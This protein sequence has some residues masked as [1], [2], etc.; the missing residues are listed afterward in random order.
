MSTFFKRFILLFCG[1]LFSGFLVNAQV[2]M[3]AS[4]RVDLAT[5]HHQL[6]VEKGVVHPDLLARYPI[7]Q[8]NGSY[9]L[10]FLG[11]ISE[12]FNRTDLIK[13][14]F[15]V[16]S[17]IA[18]LVSIKVPLNKTSQ[19]VNIKGLAYLEIA[20]KIHNSLDK[21]IVDMRADSVHQGIGLPQGYSGKDVYIGVTDWGFDYTNPVFYDTAMQQ[22][23]IVAAWDQ[24]KTSGPH[25]QGFAYGTEYT[26]QGELLAAGSDTAN[27]Y[28]YATH[29]THVSCIAGGGGAGTPHKG[30]AYDA[31]FL[32]VT[33]LVDEAA[34]LDAWEWMYQKAQADGKRLV[35]NMSWGLYHFGTLDG[36]SILSQ[37]IT[38]YTDLGVVFANSGGNNG[39]VNFHIKKTFNQDQFKSRIEFYSYSANANMWGQSVHAWGEAGNSFEN[40]LLITNNAGNTLIESPFY[41]TAT[42]TNYI[43][44]FLVTGI[45]TIWFNITAD[46]AHPLNGR[47]QMRLRV[48]NTNTALRVLLKSKA[49][50]GTVHYWNVTELSNDVGNWGMPFSFSYGGSISGDN[51]N[52]ISEPS[53]SE[54]V[55][56][57]AAYS[58]QYLNGSGNPV[59][60][61]IASF[62]SVG[63]RYD[64]QMKPDIAA[65]G[66]AIISAMSSFTDATFSSVDNVSFNNKTYHFAKMSGTSMA[67]P[68][69]AGVS[70]LILEANPYLSARQVKEIIMLTA[71]E[72]NLTGNIPAEGSPIWG[73]GKINAYAAVKL[74]L[75]TLGFEKVPHEIDWNVY[76]N[77]VMNEL[78][79]TI[80]E[81]PKTVDII[82]MEGS[83]YEK[84][85]YDGKV[86]V[87]DLPTGTYFIRLII[88][89]KVQQERFIKQ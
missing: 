28:S 60:G 61:G 81:L 30:V 1:L 58:S 82:D 6:M 19:L 45:D 75:Q 22:S 20:S 50:T 4:N 87:S 62:S 83:I 73:A 84:N 18:N 35:I 69:V 53:C 74:A 47:P 40:G 67:S 66:V 32:F 49:E 24:Y 63:P 78:H 43:D 55:I 68:M 46:A 17:P 42:V 71:R 9:Y 51:Q 52:G 65:P 72:D 76:P 36:T 57:V 48:K 8:I 54:D 33:F 37:A 29:G 89:G 77:P 2:K 56:S 25:P 86:Y 39:N 11:K 21:A 26:T 70:A 12:G 34:V 23:R 10:S 41:S 64:G 44:S 88:D 16:G 15:I 31:N 7:Y 14:G 79:F 5:I 38:A 59:G 85:I 13:R 80:V 3:S 27:I